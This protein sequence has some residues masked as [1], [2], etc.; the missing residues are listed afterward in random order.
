MSLPNYKTIRDTQEDRYANKGGESITR[1]LLEF[2]NSS[3]KK[4]KVVECEING[5]LET[6]Q[7]KKTTKEQ[8]VVVRVGRR[9]AAVLA[10]APTPPPPSFI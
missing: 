6:N 1:R 2:A 10:R 3:V 5:W 7:K 8:K 9:K 4:K